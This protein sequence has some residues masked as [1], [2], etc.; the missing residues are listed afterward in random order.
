MQH[1]IQ[2]NYEKSIG[3]HVSTRTRAHTRTY[4]YVHIY[5]YTYMYVHTRARARTHTHT[6]LNK[7]ATPTNA[8]LDA[9]MTRCKKIYYTCC[10]SPPALSC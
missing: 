9:M 4:M 1:H 8:S 6:L 7:I 2:L 5:M 3:S 10:F